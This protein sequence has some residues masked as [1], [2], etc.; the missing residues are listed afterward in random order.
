MSVEPVYTPNEMDR[1][2]LKTLEKELSRDGRNAI[3]HLLNNAL[4]VALMELD[5]R[6][7]SNFETVRAKLL[8]TADLVRVIAHG[9][10]QL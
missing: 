1:E 6:S 4:A 3:A 5:L 2:A 8:R 10:E 9:N 7:G